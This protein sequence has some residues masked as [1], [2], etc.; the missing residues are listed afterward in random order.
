MA[1]DVEIANLALTRLG[2]DVIASFSASG[3][4]AS[5]WFN[6]N[7]EIIKKA[8]L[9]SHQ[10]NFAVKRAVLS[11]DA[12]GTITAIT[13]ASPPVVTCVDH[14]FTNGDRVFIANVV[15]MT[16]VNNL[17]FTV[18]NK[19]DD[20]FELSGIVGV[21]YTAYSSGGSLYGYIPTE[22]AYRYGLP[23][24]CLRVL[25]INGGERT[26]YRLEAS[27]GNAADGATY[28]HTDAQTPVNLEYVFDVTTDANFDPIFTDVLA[29]RL[30]AEISFYLTDNS[31]LTE[32]SWKIYEQKLR[33]ARGMDAREG[34]PRGIDADT[35]T[36]ARL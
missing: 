35:W 27:L 33:E 20:T 31:T 19:T 23:S 24:D 30:S 14:G 15:G 28:I 32:Q 1:T 5:R 12:I 16:E 3:N 10:W 25:R 13:A 18:A 9:R 6:S 29:S 4:K 36:D 22:F 7:Y 34:T 11:A 17:V 26:N 2:H 8:T 21:G